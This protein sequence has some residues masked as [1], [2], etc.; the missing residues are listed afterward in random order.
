MNLLPGVRSHTVDTARLR[1][2]CIESGPEDGSPVVLVHGNLS[3]GRFYEHLLPGAPDRF[4]FIAPDMRGFGDTEKVPIDAT[5]G[6]ADWADDTHALVEALGIDRPVHLAGWSTGGAAIARYAIDRPVASLTFVAPVS[7]YGYGGTHPDGTP[8]YPDYAGSGGGAGSP[9]FT[10]RIDAGDRT[11]ES[12][13]SPRSVLNSSYWAPTHREPP[14]REDLLVDEIL[15]SV[16]G[17]DGYPG[18]ASLSDNW[19][20]IAPGTRGILNALSPKY[21]NWSAL[22]DVDPK[23]PVLWVHGTND[24]VVADGAAWEMGTLGKMGQVPGWPGEETF[25]PQQM[26]HQTRT[27]L[28]RY[29]D[30]GGRFEEESFEGSGHGPFFD[31]ADRFKERFFGFLASVAR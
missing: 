24:I 26:K 1:M 29:R 5:R 8:C 10:S 2:R 19:P 6:L 16:T 11:G 27:L 17:D 31:A 14:E 20:W 18:D 9:E 22:S 25:P 4:R 12:P 7:P 28:E 13:F 21:C 15:K 23:P 30:G 3:T